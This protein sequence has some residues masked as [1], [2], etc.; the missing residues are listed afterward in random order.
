MTRIPIAFMVLALLNSCSNKYNAFRGNY[1]CQSKDGRPDYSDLQYWAAHPMKWDPS[2]SVPA[3]LRDETADSS[4]DVFYIHPTTYTE[5]IKT[6]NAAIDDDYINAKTD[7]SPI[8]YQASVFN[9]SCR[10]FAPRYRQVSI[11]MFFEKDEA[12]R[13]KAFQTA[14]EDVTNAFSY[15]LAH[16]NNGRP[17]IIAG[18]SQGSF[19]AEEL[20]RDFFE[21]S[22]L[23]Q[24]LSRQ[25]VVAYV[26]GWAVPKG[27]FSSLKMCNDSLQTGCICSWR[28]LRNGYV[29]PYLE[30]EHDESFV[31]NPLTWTTDTY[32]TKNIKQGKRIIQIQQNV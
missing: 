5:K 19:I 28:T 10:V 14:Y 4:V 9:S 3:P 17:I 27:Y 7:Y 26:P 25:L 1:N 2:D 11:D 21:K 13:S 15:Y 31:T 6:D 18:H 20:L 12:R 8:L 24:Q 32:R 29:P 22:V 23:A 16:W 30:S